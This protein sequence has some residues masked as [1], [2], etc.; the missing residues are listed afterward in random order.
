MRKPVV[1][2]RQFRFSKLNDPQ[3]SHLKLLLG[4]IIYFS[5]YFLTENLIPSEKCIVVHGR[6]DDLI[7]FCEWFVIPYVFWYLLIVITLLYFVL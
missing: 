3:F 4:W 1:D 5:M 2:Y 6:L 7:P